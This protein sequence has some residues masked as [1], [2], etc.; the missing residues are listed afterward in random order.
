MQAS[1][2]TPRNIDT[3]ELN[4]MLDVMAAH[5]KESLGSELKDSLMFGLETG[6]LWV[7][8]A[9]HQRLRSS[10]HIDSELGSINVNFYRDD[11]SQV[12][13]HPSVGASRV[14]DL[15]DDRNI[16]LVDDVL[17]TGRT[18]RAAMNE[19]FDFG[20]P[21]RIWLAVLIDRGERQLPIHADI[22]GETW[23]VDTHQDIQL[24]GPE[25]LSLEIKEAKA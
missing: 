25:T 18:I 10:G 23:Q 12:G 1:T 3:P 4:R 24:Q 2:A 8:E 22:V 7:A 14:P 16:I 20:R 5:L 19:I 13:L 11:F 9:L 6:G 15:V 17:F 21:A